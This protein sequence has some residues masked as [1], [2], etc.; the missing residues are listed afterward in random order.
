MRILTQYI[1]I[2]T[3]LLLTAGCTR[4]GVNLGAPVL[5]KLIDKIGDSRNLRVVKEG[6]AGDILMASALT[7]LSPNNK[8]LLKE[9]AYMYFTLGLIVEDSDINYAKS[10]YQTGNSYGMRILMQNRK[11]RKGI[12]SGEPVHKLVK[13]LGKQY[14]PA[15][16]WTSL[17]SGMWVLLSLDDPA[18]F[19]EM[20]D[21]MAM[22]KR[23]IELDDTYFH[24]VVKAFLGCY[25]AMVP[26]ALDPECGPDNSAKMFAAAKKADNNAMLLYDLFEARFLAANINDEKRFDTL[27][28]KVL[29]T[30]SGILKG[31]Y[32]FNELAKEKARHYQKNK[33]DYF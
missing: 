2:L 30:D 12:E 21:I 6:M 31:G 22:A 19:M 13:H 7:E 11:F 9:C 1:A 14:A 33:K 18:A 4:M 17:N 8:R 23:S 15:L 3:I 16:C 26:K 20:A 29:T 24:S 27:L 10:M 5:S 32:L 28:E 25:Y